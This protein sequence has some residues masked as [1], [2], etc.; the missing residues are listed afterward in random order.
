MHNLSPKS[1][2]LPLQNKLVGLS[3]MIIIG[4]V[5]FVLFFYHSFSSSL[6]EEKKAQSKH[7][8]DSALGIIQHFR[9]LELSKK[10][11]TI[12]AQQMAMRT[13][14]AATYGEDG[15]FWINDSQGKI[16]IQPYMPNLVGL[17]MTNWADSSGKYIFQEFDRVAK[18]GGGWVSYTWPK[19][20]T[21]EEYPKISYVAHYT[22]WDWLV[23]T[24]IYL[25]DMKTNIF[26][27]VFKTSG[28]LLFGF[29]IFIF[30]TVVIINYFVHQ[31]SELSVRDALT[32]LYSKRFLKQVSPALL[33]HSKLTDY[34][35]TAIFID[36]DHFKSVNDIH[37]HDHGDLVLK[38]VATVIRN[39]AKTSD[40]CIRYGGEEFVLIGFFKNEMSAMDMAEMIRHQV[41]E[42]C[43]INDENEFSVTLSAGIAL[44]NSQS[45]AS[46]ADTLKRAD[47]KL[48][49]AKN[50]GRNRIIA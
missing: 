36:L 48:Y 42:M 46:F 30:T 34:H 39:N 24:G 3:V 38:Q 5:A 37:G 13:L 47:M 33:N 26:W 12:E 41:S 10:L 22:D 6:E 1:Y 18:N 21:S 19:L 49:E 14:E 4:I 9:Q 29:F 27:A 16:L 17:N 50:A 20:N 32:N 15:Y 35:L 8:V 31:L 23:G 2:R 43:F 44:H 7:F 40:Y 28:F 11:T 45:D 25:D